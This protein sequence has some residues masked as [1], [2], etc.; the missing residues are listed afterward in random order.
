[1]S[2]LTNGRKNVLL[3]THGHW[4]HIG[5]VE[6][7]RRHGGIVYAHPADRRHLTD[8]DWHWQLLF[9]QFEQDFDV[10]AA[11]KPTFYD[12]V[13][14]TDLDETVAEGQVLEFDQLRFRVLETPGHSGGSVCFLEETTGTLFTGDALIGDGFFGGIPQI[15]NYAAYIKSMGRLE[16]LHVNQVLTDHTDPILGEELSK[17]AQASQD[18]ALRMLTAVRNYADTAEI[19]TVGSAAKAIADAEGKKVGGGTCVSALAALSALNDVPQAQECAK[20]YI[21]GA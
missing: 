2:L 6:L 3:L 15:E 4:D 18:C 13:T 12:T 16:F 10:P 9:G 8:P 11:R 19:I 17:L 5:G 20:K 21:F 7:I 14:G 1:M